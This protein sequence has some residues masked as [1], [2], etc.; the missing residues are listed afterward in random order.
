[1]R[2]L[3][4]MFKP[5][6]ARPFMHN[7]SYTEI[8]PCQTLKPYVRCFWGAPDES[9]ALPP[10][11]AGP[12]LV[13]PDVCM[14]IIFDA[15]AGKPA[16]T[17]FFAG[18]FDESFYA[19]AGDGAASSFAIRFYC[20]AVPLFSDASMNG[21]LNG[22][23]V[24]EAYFESIGRALAYRLALCPTLAEKVKTAEDILLRKL[25]P[26]RQ[27]HNVLN[28]VYRLLLTKGAATVSDLCGYTAVGQ[29]QLERLFLEYIGAGPKKLAGLVRYQYL[30][31]DIV[32]NGSFDIQ[33]AVFRYAYTDQ[34]HLLNDFR[35]YHAMTPARAR[36]MAMCVPDD[37]F[38]QYGRCKTR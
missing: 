35:K 27:N 13:I 38:L 5:L 29:R 21:C 8:A 24:I 6:T 10:A 32:Q 31:Q 25:D 18:L 37:G 20:W 9:A 36:A 26:G 19:E 11:A 3:S 7:Q 16:Q 15:R 1:M 28:A 2:V 14:D 23:F 22:R 30:W 4:N 17:G 34:A 12:S 33:D